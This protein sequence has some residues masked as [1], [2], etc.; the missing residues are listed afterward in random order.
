MKPSIAPITTAAGAGSSPP[1]D[2]AIVGCSEVMRD[3]K[4]DLVQVAKSTSTVLIT[5]ET[6][7]GKELAAEFI[8]RNSPRCHKAC[9]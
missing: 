6:G 2:G 3:L 8:H 5:G 4:L 7:T 1:V 9:P